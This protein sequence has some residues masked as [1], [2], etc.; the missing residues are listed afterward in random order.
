MKLNFSPSQ[1]LRD[2]SKRWREALRPKREDAARADALSV[3]LDQP[4]RRG[5]DDRRLE[6]PLGRFCASYTPLGHPNGLPPHLL[7]AGVDYRNRVLVARQAMGLLNAGWSP[8]T[9]GYKADELTV[10]QA[11][12]KLREAREKQDEAD[13]ALKR[14]RNSLPSLMRDLCVLEIEHNQD[15]SA[16][17]HA[18]LVALHSLFS[19]GRK[20]SA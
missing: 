16:F 13:R 12:K 2:V 9:S 6:S 17:L 1:H 11:A 10:A 3:V 20:K 5:N 4:H 14:I 18:G 19:S 15:D 7:Q 8:G